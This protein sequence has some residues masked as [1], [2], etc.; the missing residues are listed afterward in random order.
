MEEALGPD[1]THTVKALPPTSWHLT[2]VF[3]WVCKARGCAYRACGARGYTACAVRGVHGCAVCAARVYT[4][5]GRACDTA[6][7]HVCAAG[8]GSYAIPL[9]PLFELLGF[10][11]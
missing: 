9:P 2:T 6:L 4:A 10:F 11:S 3:L 1:N 7:V 8:T 5:T